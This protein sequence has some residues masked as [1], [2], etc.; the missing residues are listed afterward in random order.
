MPF[1][2]ESY[3]IDIRW[4]T[5]DV[6]IVRPDLDFSECV[7]VLDYVQENHN[8]EVGINWD[9][10]L[11]SANVLYPEIKSDTSEEEQ[12]RRDDYRLRHREHEQEEKRPY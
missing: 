9:V 3:F 6:Q 2:N 8:A 12:N 4:S 5:E 10:L 11:E 1:S 7:K